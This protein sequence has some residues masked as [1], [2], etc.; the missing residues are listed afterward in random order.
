MSLGCGKV[1][2]RRRKKKPGEFLNPE[3]CYTFANPKRANGGVAERFIA[4]VLKTD[5]R[6]ERTGGS[7]PS[8]SAYA[9]RSLGEGGLSSCQGDTH[10]RE[11]SSLQGSGGRVRQVYSTRNIFA[12][13]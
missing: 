13:A 8:P 10:R 2:F 12:L 9:R 11:P 5:V 6:D 1:S 7:N 4:P 3:W